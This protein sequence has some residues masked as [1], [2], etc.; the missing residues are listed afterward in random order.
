MRS[1]LKFDCHLNQLYQSYAFLRTTI[2]FL[3]LPEQNLLKK[4]YSTARNSHF[5]SVLF[6]LS[7]CE[8]LNHGVCCKEIWSRVLQEYRVLKPRNVQENVRWGSLINSEN[9]NLKLINKHSNFHKISR[10]ISTIFF[11][12]TETDACI[13]SLLKD[14]FSCHTKLM[15]E[16]CIVLISVKVLCNKLCIKI[17]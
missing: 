1:H 13:C 8:F 16:Q 14:D 17:F 6:V 3:K 9:F 15:D 7:V 2:T 12:P 5:S 11:D 4:Y 10:N